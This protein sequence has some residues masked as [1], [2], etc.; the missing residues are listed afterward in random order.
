LIINKI[1]PYIKGKELHKTIIRNQNSYF[2]YISALLKYFPQNESIQDNDEKI[3]LCGDSHSLALS[4][5]LLKGKILVPKLVTGMKCWH[6]REETLFFTKTNFDNVINTIPQSATVIFIFGEIDCREGIIGAVEKC[7]Y[8]SI[9]QGIK[10]TADI[11]L[12][13]IKNLIKKKEITAMMHPVPPVLDVT[14]QFVTGFNEYLRNE[15]PKIN[16][17]KL[18]FMDFADDLLST[19]KLRFNTEYNLDNTHMAPTYIK[20]LEKYFN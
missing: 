7:K 4:W 3:Y 11:Y 9:E 12:N 8:D 13:A 20:L 16:N 6:M 14:R 1:E 2:L 10:F 17:S 19:D 5:H 18:I 15:I